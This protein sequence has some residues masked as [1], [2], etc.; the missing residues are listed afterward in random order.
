MLLGGERYVKKGSRKCFYHA[1]CCYIVVF[2]H[3]LPKE[4]VA[5]AF[6]YVLIL[7]KYVSKFYGFRTIERAVV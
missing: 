4:F 6:Y 1:D 7:N 5:C 2:G 3:F